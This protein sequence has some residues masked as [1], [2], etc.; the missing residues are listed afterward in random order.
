MSEI[1]GFT[2]TRRGMTSAQHAAVY[3]RLALL[4]PLALVHG[5]CHGADD[6]V[7]DVA[8]KLNIHRIV[9]PSTLDPSRVSRYRGNVTVHEPKLPLERNDD[10]VR[11]ISTL[12]AAPHTTIEMVRSGTWYTVRRAREVRGMRVIVILPDGSQL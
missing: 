9:R 2:G 11:E 10:I 4:Q 1:V 5:G 3:A 12:L 8:V 6:E 7:D